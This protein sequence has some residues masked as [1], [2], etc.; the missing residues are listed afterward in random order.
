MLTNSKSTQLS[1]GSFGVLLQVELPVTVSV[2]RAE[3]PLKE[4]LKLSPGSVVEL[5]RIVGD[6]VDVIV[7]NRVFAKGEIVVVDDNY[8]VR[9]R[10]VCRDDSDSLVPNSVR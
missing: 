9:I 7:N 3:M 1:T 8:A 2:G 4:L 5:D 10:E 6:P